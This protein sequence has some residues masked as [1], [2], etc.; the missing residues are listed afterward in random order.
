MSITKY[1]VFRTVAQT[2]NFTKAADYMNMTQSAV[3]KAIKS[4]ENEFGFSLFIRKKDGVVLSRAGERV[5]DEIISVVNADRKLR[6]VINDYNNLNKGKLVIGSFSSA[7]TRLLP[8]LLA[9]YSRLYP[10][11]QITI[12]EGHYDEIQRW[13]EDDFVDI[14]LLTEEFLDQDYIKQ[15]LFTDHIKLIVPK[16]FNLT[17]QVVSIKSI[18]KYPF[19]A[20]EHFPNPYLLNLIQQYDLNLDMRFIVKTNQT[21]FAFVEMGL[22]VALIPESSVMKTGYLFDVIDLKEVIPRNI[23]VVTKEQNMS[24][25][26]VK[27]F[28]Q[29]NQSNQ[30]D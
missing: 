24:I 27:A 16:Q 5:L 9:K 2:N 18:E 20:T 4:L 22:G 29:L 26:M 23:Y 19:I 17:N 7:S 28:W 8:S 30:S 25:P 6:N 10:N 1:E 13:I 15:Y 12:K 3:S 21:V 11:I 14:G